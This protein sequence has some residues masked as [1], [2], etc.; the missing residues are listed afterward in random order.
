MDFLADSKLACFFET[1]ALYII[2][3]VKTP[4]GISGNLY[5]SAQGLFH[6]PYFTCAKCI[7]NSY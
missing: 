3:M 1:P 6:A 2:K 5:G 4:E 7:Q